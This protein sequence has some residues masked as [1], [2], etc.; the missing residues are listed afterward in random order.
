MHLTSNTSPQT[1]VTQITHVTHQTQ[2]SALL[3]SG[4]GGV[5]QGQQAQSNQ[6]SF[7]GLNGTQ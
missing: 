7:G 5:L 3:T 6:R 2:N 4:L 1:Q